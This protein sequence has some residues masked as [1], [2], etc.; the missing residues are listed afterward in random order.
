M[1]SL[2]HTKEYKIEAVLI[3]ERGNVCE[4]HAKPQRV[5]LALFL[6]HPKPSASLSAE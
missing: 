2:I 4:L 6:S 3:T 1:K 5:I